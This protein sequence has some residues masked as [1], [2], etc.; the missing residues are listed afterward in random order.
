MLKTLVTFAYAVLLLPAS[1][2][3]ARAPRGAIYGFTADGRRPSHR[4]PR[5]RKYSAIAV[6]PPYSAQPSGVEW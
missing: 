5:A 6:C 2:R 4:P 3:A 1:A